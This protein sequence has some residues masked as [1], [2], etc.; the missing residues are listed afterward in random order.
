MDD[1]DDPHTQSGYIEKYFW[2]PMSV[3]LDTAGRVYITDGNRHRIQGVQESTK[4]TNAG[5][6]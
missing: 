2:A 3:K 5:L 6:I 1:A 4:L